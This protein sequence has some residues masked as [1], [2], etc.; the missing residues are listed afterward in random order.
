MSHLP[1]ATEQEKTQNPN[2]ISGAKKSAL[3]L[4]SLGKEEAAKIMAHLDD[5]M[6]EQIVLEM[7]RIRQVTKI[8]RESVLEEFR[9]AI[10]QARDEMQTGMDAARELLSK[11]VGPGKA[12]EILKKLD[13][14]EASADFEFLNEMEPQIL[15]SFLGVESPQTIA[16]TLAYL[17][18]RQAAEVLKNLPKEIQSTVALK[19]ANTSKT[20]PDA[21]QEIAKILKKK[22]ET[23]DKLEFSQAGGAEALANI[24]NFMDKSMEETILGELNQKSPDLATQVKDKLYTFEDIL[25]LDNKEMRTLVNQ[26]GGNE[27]MIIGLRGA[28]EEIKRHFFSAM[29]Q[30]RASD[31]IE[32]MDSRGKLTLKDITQARNEILKIARQLEEDGVIILKKRKEEFI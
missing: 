19:L 14:K 11:S 23:R 31:I 28:G 27:Y 32:E 5:K 6:I 7:S 3:L 16:V 22:Y 25:N 9:A 20:H 21:I 8:Q 12:D 24:L 18:P 29:S 30:N 10:S 2:E 17:Q 13:K 1:M 26:L 4:L 15:A